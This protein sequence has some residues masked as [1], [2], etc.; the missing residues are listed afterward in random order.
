[1]ISMKMRLVRRNLIG[2]GFWMFLCGLL[3]GLGF[4]AFLLGGIEVYPGKSYLS[5]CLVLKQVGV[6]AILAPSP[7]VSWLS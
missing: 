1:M 5:L 7:I 3:G 6:D 4:T 2:H